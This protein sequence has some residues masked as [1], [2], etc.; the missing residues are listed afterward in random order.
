MMNTLAIEKQ[1]IR[2]SST[3]P[4]YEAAG[5]VTSGVRREIVIIEAGWGSSGYYSEA[6]LERDIPRIF[7]VGTHMYL[8]HPTAQEDTER[9]ERD[10]RDLVAVIDESPRMAGIK[11]VAVARI[12]EHWLPVFEDEAFLAAIGTSIRA[13]GISEEADN[14]GKRGPE[15]TA[16]TEGLSVDF[17]TLAGAGGSIGPLVESVR[18]RIT[19]L[20]ESARAVPL[21][22]TLSSDLRERLCNA[23]TEAWGSED[24]YVYCEDFDEVAGYAVFWINP[25]DEAGYY[26]KQTFSTSTDGDVEFTGDPET[27]ERQ[28]DYVPAEENKPPPQPR[29]MEEARNAGNWFESRIH[30]DFTVMADRLFGEGYL[31]REE[32]ITLSSAIGDGLQAFSAYLEENA[33]QLFQRDPYAELTDAQVSYLGEKAKRL[34]SRSEQEEEV[35]EKDRQRLADLEESVRDLTGKLQEATERADKAEER[36][37][38]A[39][40]GLRLNE[41]GRVALKAVEAVE[42]LRAVPKAQVR[43]VEASLRGE[44]PTDSQGRLDKDALTERATQKAKEEL[45]YLGLVQGEGVKGLGE[46]RDRKPASENGNGGGGDDTDVLSEA[47]EGLGMPEGAAKIGAEGR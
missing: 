38:R 37:D 19:P 27:V 36:A 45:E 3:T 44:L 20:I 47:L 13:F 33:P 5:A 24:V 1:N 34:P 23:G 4:F 17:V 11:S 14:G 18:E 26:Y 15:I 8:N 2:E 16:L 12:F 40:D 6:V 21:D 31:T 32:R 29:V 41:A 35:D 22:E 30:Q 46:S 7:P 28:T 42:A 9:P 43:A 25:D 10:L 39:E